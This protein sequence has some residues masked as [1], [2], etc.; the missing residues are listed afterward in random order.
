MKQST[1]QTSSFS[2]CREI[3]HFLFNPNFQYRI[4]KSPPLLP[5]LSQI[6]PSNPS[7]LFF[8]LCPILP[9]SLFPP[10][11]CT[12]TLYVS[13]SP[14]RATCPAYLVIRDLITE[15]IFTGTPNTVSKVPRVKLIVAQG[16]KKFI[17]FCYPGILLP[18][19]PFSCTSTPPL[20]LR[21]LL[22]L[23][24]PSVQHTLH[25]CYVVF[26]FVR[27]FW[28]TVPAGDVRRHT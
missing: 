13:Y 18:S 24:L 20:A 4:H 15:I 9:I 3:P 5:I 10:G 27:L 8:H 16:F 2:A 17:S 26:V 25:L 6:N 19:L 22:P 23:P 28:C 12:K 21:S 11:F 7:Q 14:K 1:L